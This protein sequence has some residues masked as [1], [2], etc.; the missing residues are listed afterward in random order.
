MKTLLFGILAVLIVA[1]PVFAQSQ[2]QQ[3]QMDQDIAMMKKD[4]QADKS[5]LITANMKFTP[6]EAAAFWP[7]YKVYD[8]ALS[9]VADKRVALIKDYAQNYGG[10]TNEKASELI[11]ALFDTEVQRLQ[12]KKDLFQSL[13]KVMSAKSA[14]RMIQVE[15]RL[16]MLIDLQVA[17]GIPL[18]TK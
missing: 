8:E 5:T 15:N 10:M 3:A 17:S 6:E 1:V 12:L 4:I 18:V 14:A 13:T 2:T 7:V 9:K 16:N 11:S